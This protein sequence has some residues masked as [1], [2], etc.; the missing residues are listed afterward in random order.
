MSSVTT[1]TT[2]DLCTQWTQLSNDELTPDSVERLLKPI[3]DDLWVAAACVDRITDDVTVQRSLLD[4][5]L[6]RTEPASERSREAFED[7][8]S[9]A[10]GD[11]DESDTGNEVGGSQPSEYTEAQKHA[12][13]VVYFRQE[14]ADAQLCRIRDVL[15]DR[16]DRLNTFVDICKEFP[17]K[18]DDDS[19]DDE[20]ADD[21]WAD[22]TGA[23]GPASTPAP[24][25]SYDPPIALSEFLTDDLFGISCMLAS[26]EQF[27]ALRIL[28]ERHGSYLWPYRLEILHH[29]PEHTSPLLYK[30]VLPMYDPITSQEQTPGNK[31]W[32]T[33]LDFAQKSS[34]RAVLAE[35]GE[36]LVVAPV[37]ETVNGVSPHA[38]LLTSVEL[39]AW[40][41]ERVDLI[42]SATGMLDAAL[43]LVQHGAS[44]GLP[45]LDQ[46]GEDLS[47]LVR[48]VYDVPSS[49]EHADDEWTL[50]RW[51]SM[52]PPSVVR[53][54]L[55]YSTPAT[56]AKDINRLVMPYLFVAESRAERAGR[57]DP[58][59]ATNLLY[60]YILSAPLN[61]VQ[62]IFEA[63]KPTLPPAE[64]LIR[65]DE[66][67]IRLALSCLYGSDSLDQWSTM[68]RIFEC[69]PAWET[70]GNGEDDADAADTT[71]ASLGAFVT[72]TT[73]RPRCTPSDLLIF[74]KPLPW[75]SLSHALDILDV[76]LESGEILS[77]WGVPA[78]LKWFLQSNADIQE[79]R[80]W[81][82]RLA[83]RADASEDKLETQEDW[84]WLLEDMLKLS[85]SG[86]SDARGAFCFLSRDDIVRIFFSGLLS[87]G[88]KCLYSACKDVRYR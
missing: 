26:H 56:I 73:S 80:A 66:D 11:E 14:S 2:P 85:G 33:E 58:S 8:F 84:V 44:Q 23:A 61:I 87:T 22:E 5:G 31:P 39:A 7:S 34:T 42:I 18:S 63:S 17:S 32:R 16:L 40:Y 19:L 64:R 47:L 1:T 20:W 79:Q 53:A 60:D 76:H 69:L 59:L 13:L 70:E 38:E 51:T 24:S 77:R 4:L 9:G 49:V 57:P 25:T 65:N 12:A 29:I 28:L 6:R 46:L 88:S 86:E 71:I 74:F 75:S 27:G 72:P 21:P 68:S 62:A 43:S 52:D 35:C 36:P 15:L 82:N 45:G 3:H 50:D 37:S 78:P 55:K 41:R 30:D 10:I 83:R 67:M 48:L 54:Y 81:A